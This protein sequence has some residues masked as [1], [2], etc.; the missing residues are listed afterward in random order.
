VTNDVSKEII[1]WADHSEWTFAPQQE[2]SRKT[3]VKIVDAAVS[4]FSAK[5][6]ENTSVMD[7][8]RESGVSVGAIYTR[9]ADKEA[10]LHT[11]FSSYY[12]T[13]K[14]QFDALTEPELWQG[15]NV[16]DVVTFYINILFS[17][18]RQD[19]G[20]LRVAERQRLSNPF[21]AESGASVNRHVADRLGAM[22]ELHANCIGGDVRTKAKYLHNILR[23][24]LVVA[25]LQDTSPVPPALAIATS[26]FQSEALAMALA[27]LG[28]DSENR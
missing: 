27:Y 7:I 3:L 14:D 15:K 11:V 23:N 13:R 16:T 9:F 1:K 18:F 4:L 8:S 2:R 10:I 20:M 12:R 5:G 24:A 19:A 22:L 28:L 6:F 25:I 26:E 17:S 21:L